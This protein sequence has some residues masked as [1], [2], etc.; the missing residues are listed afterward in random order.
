MNVR[1]SAIVSKTTDVRNGSEITA[2]DSIKGSHF[3]SNLSGF[4]PNSQ[5]FNIN[6]NIWT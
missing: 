4:N 1:C 6:P 3:F 2:F 5:H